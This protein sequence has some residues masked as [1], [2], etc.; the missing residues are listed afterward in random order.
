MI[1]K[2][3]AFACVLVVSCAI[4]Q[5]IDSLVRIMRDG[6]GRDAIAAQS[7]LPEHLRKIDPNILGFKL[8]LEDQGVTQENVHTARLHERYKNNL[9]KVDSLGRFLLRVEVQKVDGTTET[10]LKKLGAKIISS[11][12]SFPNYG[13]W[14]SFSDIEG[15]SRLKEV[16]G[17]YAIK[18]AV[19]NTGKKSSAGV[20][21]RKHQ[22][23]PQG[24]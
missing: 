21:S 19:T 2:S 5:D 15:I 18:R 3:S 17:I 10:S 1:L 16:R 20:N 22:A 4:S 23:E 9:I 7:Q 12:S 13:C 11:N 6:K 24:W 14:V 8:I